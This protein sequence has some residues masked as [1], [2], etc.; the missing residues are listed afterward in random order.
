MIL[1]AL[2]IYFLLGIGLVTLG[3]L[4]E[5]IEGT[6]KDASRLRGNTLADKIRESMGE[7]KIETPEIKVLAFIVLSFIALVL[8]WP[9]WLISTLKARAEEKRALKTR[10]G[11][12]FQMMGGCGTI[13]CRKCDFSE[14]ITSFMHGKTVE[15]EDC[16][17][18][19]Y[20]CLSCGKF[21]GIYSEGHKRDAVEPLCECG[22]ILSRDHILFCPKCKS[23]DLSYGMI[24]IT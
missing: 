23:T 3:P 14:D 13:H 21:K 11:T 12:Q 17:T 9:V 18:T 5:L 4:K 7:E 1:T 22:G 6:F 16:C 24:S 15:G 20:Q 2:V 10:R 19:G 8:L